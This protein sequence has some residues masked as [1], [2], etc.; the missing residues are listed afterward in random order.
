MIVYGFKTDTVII[1]D[2]TG[3]EIETTTEANLE[4][5]RPKV[6]ANK[7]EKRIQDKLSEE[8]KNIMI[9]EN[10]RGFY[11]SNNTLHYF[12]LKYSK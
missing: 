2:K 11:F 4:Q 8:R 1:Y 9:V 6:I 7:L 3:K 5:V 10:K 12:E